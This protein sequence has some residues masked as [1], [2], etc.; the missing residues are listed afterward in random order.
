MEGFK[1]FLIL[2]NESKDT[3]L[4]YSHKV[5]KCLQDRGMTARVL[6][7]GNYVDIGHINKEELSGVDCVIVM[8]GD[9]TMLQ[10]SHL[11]TGSDIP[12]IGVNLGTVGFLTEVITDEI[13][14]MVEKLISGDFFIEERM[15]LESTVYRNNEVACENVH[16]LNDVVL[17]RQTYLKLI[18][19]K[20]YLNGRL[21]DTCEADGIILS[22]PTGST[23]YNLSAGGP[24]VTPDARLI[25]LT[26]ISPYSHSRHS[27]VF[28]ADDKISLEFVAKRKDGDYAGIVSFDG[29]DDYQISPGDHIDVTSSTDTL[30]LIRFSTSS[31]YEVL[32]KKLT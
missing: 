6:V 24:I 27:V 18:A 10:A 21:F 31:V 30:K 5:E 11:L 25:V 15:M 14:E 19:V 7:G 2:A 3:D 8:G 4:V 12:M 28:G 29:F 26:P 13:S 1:N 20:I 32:K 23:G 9:G 16:A 17:A 22:T